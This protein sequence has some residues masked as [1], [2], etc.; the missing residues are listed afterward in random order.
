MKYLIKTSKDF[1]NL[2][3]N[4]RNKKILIITGKKSFRKSGAEEIFKKLQDTAECL[5]FNYKCIASIHFIDRNYEKAMHNLE[6]SLTIQKEISMNILELETKTYCYLIYKN[7][8]KK[9]NEKEIQKLIEEEENIEYK[10]NLRLY[11]LLE[12]NSYLE[13][14]HNQVQEKADNLEPD[15]AA[16]FLGYPIPKAIVEEWEKVTTNK[17]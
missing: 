11:E 12:E 2:L 13:T 10:L 9:Y 7:I 4:Y 5:I 17:N 15:I 14:A 1:Q 6:K 16:K 3:N 8:G